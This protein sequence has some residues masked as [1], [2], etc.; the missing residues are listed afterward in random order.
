M[1]LAHCL[2]LTW[3]VRRAGLGLPLFLVLVPPLALTLTGC[4]G[5]GDSSSSGTTTTTTSTSTT[6]S[7]TDAGGAGG[8]GGTGGETTTSSTGGTGG[9]PPTMHTV[10]FT[11]EPRWMGVT[12]VD[13]V[14]GFNKPGDWKFASPLVSL[15]DDGA[16]KW[17]ASVDLLDGKYLFLYRVKGDVDGLPMHVRYSLDPSVSVVAACPPESPTFSDVSTNPCAQIVVP[18]P[19]A[20]PVHHI[21][22]KVLYDGAP[23]AGYLVV[24]DSDETDFGPYFEN[25]TN[26]GA[27]GTFDLT[28]PNGMHRIQVQHPSYLTLDDAERD[29]Y[30]LKAFRRSVSSS[31]FVGATVAL[32]EVDMAYLDYDKMSPTMS[33]TLPTTFEI[34]I[35]PSYTTARVAVYGGVDPLA[36][37]VGNAWFQSDNVAATSVPFD[38]TFN[39]TSAVGSAVVPGDQ[40][41]WGTYHYRAAGVGKTWRSQ[42]MVLPITWP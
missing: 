25:R 14:G 28:A 30:T 20:A 40:Y 36:P 15:K 22:G 37:S 17:T 8:A 13:V 27:D 2:R 29:P 7:S 3:T 10:T 33:A 23:A 41:Y 9:A 39:T 26:S 35:P 32:Q 11:Y 4:G 18:Q 24:L 19:A 42:S 21:T 5:G 1:T 6:S 38:G 31:F 12:G 16:G 34:S